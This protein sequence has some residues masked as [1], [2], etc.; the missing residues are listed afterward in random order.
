MLPRRGV[1]RCCCSDRRLCRVAARTV[2]AA[3]A[4]A[5]AVKMPT[6]VPV[7]AE[8]PPPTEL[9]CVLVPLTG[10]P[11]ASEVASPTVLRLLP[12]AWVPFRLSFFTFPSAVVL[13]DAGVFEGWAAASLVPAVEDGWEG[14]TAEGVLLAVL[15]VATGTVGSA[16]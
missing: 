16:G 5:T 7:E 3:T 4:T 2:Q 10:V 6:Y 14:A 13:L 12:R 11:V 1:C 8:E 9:A 15:G